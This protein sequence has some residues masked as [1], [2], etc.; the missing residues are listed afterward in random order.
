MQEWEQKDLQC[1]AV[2]LRFV[3]VL[4]TLIS[5]FCV[6]CALVYSLISYTDSKCDSSGQGCSRGSGP[7]QPYKGNLWYFYKSDKKRFHIG[8]TSPAHHSMNH[9]CFKPFTKVRHSNASSP[10]IVSFWRNSSPRP[11]NGALPLDPT[12]GF[13]PPDT[14]YWTAAIYCQ[15]AKPAPV[16]GPA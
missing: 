11:F 8:S 6:S 2:Y 16:C 4:V 15:L 3:S 14:L 12:D 9:K 13:L 5:F 10:N 7:P 1:I